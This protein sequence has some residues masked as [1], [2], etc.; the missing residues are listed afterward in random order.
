MRIGKNLANTLKALLLIG[1]FGA[2]AVESLHAKNCSQGS[3]CD[4]CSTESCGG[5]HPG[6]CPGLG[7]DCTHHIGT[8]C[9][10]TIHS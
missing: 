3:G 2:A 9:N 6:V 7:H 8:S 1:S 5:Y 10:Q 4:C